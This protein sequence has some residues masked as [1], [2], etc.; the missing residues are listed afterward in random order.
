MAGHQA[1][2]AIVGSPGSGKTTTGRLLAARLD[3]PFVE[4]DSIFHQADWTDLPREEFRARVATVLDAER[5]VVDGNYSAV[6]DLVWRVADTVVWL[7]LPRRVVMRRV[8]VRTVRRAITREELWN[9]NREP[10]TNF[11]RLDP[12]QNIIRWTWV[13]YADYRRRY[14]AALQDPGFAHLDFVRLR[15]QRAIDA[16]VG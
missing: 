13:K 8:I 4:L 12:E 5:W 6:R 11:Y 14:A 10:L 7:D 3:A 9:G 1:R 16:F 15:S 2:V